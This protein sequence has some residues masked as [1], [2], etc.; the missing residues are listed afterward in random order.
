MGRVAQGNFLGNSLC[1]VLDTEERTNK[2]REPW[3]ERV[4]G[5]GQG[6]VTKP[7]CNRPMNFGVKVPHSLGMRP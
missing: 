6:R 7:G 2:N 1:N 3:R 4:S 5:K